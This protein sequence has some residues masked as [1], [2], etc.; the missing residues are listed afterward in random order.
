ME[1]NYF[2]DKVALVTGSSMGIG[3]AIA[4]DLAAKG[5]KIVLNGRH[6]KKLFDTELEF[7]KNQYDA[8][9]VVADIRFPQQCQHLIKETIKK[10]TGLFAVN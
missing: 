6:T 1:S 4:G 9:A 7:L 8:K 10:E 5:A 3:K 2:S